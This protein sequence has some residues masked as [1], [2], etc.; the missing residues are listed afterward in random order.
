MADRAGNCSGSPASLAGLV[1]ESTS[2]HLREDHLSIERPETECRDADG[3]DLYRE[4]VP[5]RL[6]VKD[7]H[8]GIRKVEWQLRSSRG[9]IEEETGVLEIRPDG[10]LDGEGCGEWVSRKS[11]R[12]LVV[13]LERLCRCV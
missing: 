5:L 6:E 11:D 8:S 7:H 10:S 4:K 1:L 12:N 3:W 13:E 2:F 9:L